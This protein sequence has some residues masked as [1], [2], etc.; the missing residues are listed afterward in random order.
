MKICVH[1]LISNTNGQFDE[2][3]IVDDNGEVIWIGFSGENNILPNCPI[4]AGTYSLQYYD[5]PTEGYQDIIL[6]GV[7]NHNF[8]ECHIGNYP[9]LNPATGHGDSKGCLL[10]GL[11]LDDPSNPTMVCSSKE[12]FAEFMSKLPADLSKVTITIS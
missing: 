12:G 11:T 4:Q 9:N 3:H 6:I 1:R 5:S 10:I 2:V 8:I 7:P